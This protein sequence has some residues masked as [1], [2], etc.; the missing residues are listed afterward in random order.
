MEEWKPI[1]DWPYEVS[2]QGRVRRSTPEA[3]TW[4]GRILHRQPD[5]GGYLYVVLCKNGKTKT[6]K[7]H[8][9]VCTVFNG[10]K[11]PGQQV[12]HWDGNNTNNDPKN[13]FWGT[14]KQ[15]AEDRDRHGHQAR[16][17]KAPR[18]LL[19]QKEVDELRAA[20]IQAGIGRQRV[21]RG[22]IPKMATKYNVSTNTINCI[23]SGR[24]YNS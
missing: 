11:Q 3:S 9:L 24:G 22:W 4:I 8:V 14:S 6:C 13:L 16:G 19:T 23:C 7:I 18:A 5:R 12:R 21:P 10:P 17:E 20:Y 2:N 1:P 15:N